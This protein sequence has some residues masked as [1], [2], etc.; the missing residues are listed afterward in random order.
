MNI[1]KFSSGLKFDRIIIDVTARC[2]LNCPVCY[3]NGKEEQDIPMASLE[4]IA[5]MYHN[6]IISLCGGEP[7]LRDDLPKIIKLF[8]RNNTVFLVTNGLRL[9][10]HDYV[11][12]LKK[13]G[14]KYISFSFNG[15]SEKAYEKINGRPLLGLKLKALENIKK[16][17]IKTILS[18]L[19]VKG[20][21]ENE[22]KGIF[23]YCIKNSDF[24]RELRIRSMVNIG[25]HL[26]YTKYTV[27][28]LLDIVC[29]QI[30][31]DKRDV[32]R[33]NELQGMLNK[34]LK[35]IFIPRECSFDFHLKKKGDRFIPVGENLRIDSIKGSHFKAVAMLQEIIKTFGI[36]MGIKG[37]LK[38]I[39]NP[40]APWVHNADI[41]KIGL[42]SWPDGKDKMPG[43][44]CRTGYYM[45]G[46]IVP[47]C[48]A[49]L[50]KN[51]TA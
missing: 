29:N 35:T 4:K 41:F 26:N 39:F 34:V 31:I 5:N 25:R 18:V 45:N 17:N 38:I 30:N 50:L 20:I 51:N 1:D 15:F 49:N 8:S 28:E 10:D 37:V 36:A 27:S 42:R 12:F 6:K 14:L 16:V 43:Q 11:M 40:G 2:N 22:I 23:G 21:N 32:Y 9:T 7:T 44:I 13:E 19:I 46:K 47:F 24:I 33:E 3:H 48:Y